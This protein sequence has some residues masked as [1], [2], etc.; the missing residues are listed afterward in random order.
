MRRNAVIL[1]DAAISVLTKLN[2]RGHPKRLLYV[3]I[4]Y[5]LRYYYSTAV[6][7]CARRAK[8]NCSTALGRKKYV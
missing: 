3:W 1:S 6:S 7:E 5:A 8:L 2:S 4:Q